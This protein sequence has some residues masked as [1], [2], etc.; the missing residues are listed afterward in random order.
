MHVLL[1]RIRKNLLWLWLGTSIMIFS[2]VFIQTISGKFVEIEFFV[3]AWTFIALF[4]S[5]VFLLIVII[6]NKSNSKVID[7]TLPKTL[8]AI[9]F[10]YS[11]LILST[12]FYLPI[13]AREQ[14]I[15]HYL[16]LSYYWIIPVQC[17]LLLVIF[18][19]FFR[20]ERDFKPE[21]VFIE[22]CKLISAE[23]ESHSR[24]DVKKVAIQLLIQ[25]DVKRTLKYLSSQSDSPDNVLIMLQT[26]YNHWERDNILFLESREDLE[27][28]L[29]QIRYAILTHIE[30]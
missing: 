3:W 30:N 6:V 20:K 7:Q 11:I 8:L 14:S 22:K 4:P 15:K 13:A 27:L 5:A 17:I 2:L 18:L 28:R 10:I 16:N 9:E 12:L 29:N 25:H 1:N 24:T 19:V 21:S 23:L 26:Q